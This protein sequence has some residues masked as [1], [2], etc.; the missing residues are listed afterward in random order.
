[1][2]LTVEISDECLSQDPVYCEDFE[3][4][5]RCFFHMEI[6]R[7]GIELYNCDRY[8][9]ILGFDETGQS[10]KCKECKIK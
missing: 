1:M 6:E 7:D 4:G 10:L 8:N 5:F 3:T 9:K 2:K